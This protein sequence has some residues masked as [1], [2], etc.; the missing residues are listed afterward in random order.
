MHSCIYE[1]Y[2]DHARHVP[3]RH[4]FRYSA[5]WMYLDLDEIE[6]VF[7]NRWLWSTRR[8]AIA[9]FCREDHLGPA[10]EPLA[11]AV[12]NRI[13][14][15]G[16]P[17]PDGP[18]RL[19]TQLRYF[20]YVFNP[21]SF[22]YCFNTS[23]ND[24][25]RV[26][27]EVHNTPWGEQYCYVLD[28]EHF[29]NAQAMSAS[30]RPM[31]EKRFHVSPFMPMD[32]HY[33]WSIGAPQESLHVGIGVEREGAPIFDVDLALKRREL[34]GTA[35]ARLLVRYPWMTARILAAIYWQAFRLYLKNVPFHPHPNRQLSSSDADAL[36]ISPDTTSHE[37]TNKHP[38]YA[39]TVIED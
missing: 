10:A 32:T 36:G 5:F 20:G 29:T 17:R 13:E 12:R 9:R 38:E 35:L 34:T 2:V 18:I 3:A 21:V 37:T 15:S 14:Q 8:P 23:D 30:A 4:A 19:L 24:L 31:V 22:Y 33:H 25:E 39:E 26:I 11:C 27:A 16:R 1:G 7:R 28:P 6:D